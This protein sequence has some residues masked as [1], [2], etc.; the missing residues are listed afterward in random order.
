MIFHYHIYVIITRVIISRYRPATNAKPSYVISIARGFF[1]D[2][3][4]DKLL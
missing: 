2:L 4:I 1:R 3:S